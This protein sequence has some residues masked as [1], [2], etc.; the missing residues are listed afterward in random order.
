LVDMRRR[1][2]KSNVVKKFDA[3]QQEGID[4]QA[5]L[6]KLKEN[7]PQSKNQVLALIGAG[8]LSIGV[9]KNGE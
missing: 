7:L 2:D 9:F 6:Q 1:Q 3:G 8:M 5:Y 4:Y